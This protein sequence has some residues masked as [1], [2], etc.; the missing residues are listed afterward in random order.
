MRRLPLEMFDFV[1]AYNVCRRVRLRAVPVGNS[2]IRL[3]QGLTSG[4]ALLRLVQ[5]SGG[6]IFPSTL[7]IAFIQDD[8]SASDALQKQRREEFL[9]EH[10]RDAKRRRPDEKAAPRD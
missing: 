10:G 4:A 7:R 6:T 1:Q 2:G 3:D 9:R 5:E 8:T